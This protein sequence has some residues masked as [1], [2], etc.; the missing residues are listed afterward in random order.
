[1]VVIDSVVALY[2]V[3]MH[4]TVALRLAVG[5]SDLLDSAQLFSC[6]EE[7]VA[8]LQFV[9]AATARQRHLYKATVTSRELA[10]ALPAGVDHTG[11]VFG[12]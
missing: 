8:D 2:L 12:R 11:I 7:A 6:L 1:M 3:H 5:A 10:A 4:V 9:F